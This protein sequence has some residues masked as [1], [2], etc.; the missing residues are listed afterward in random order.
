[1]IKRKPQNDLTGKRFGILTVI[2]YLGKVNGRAG[3]WKCLCDCGKETNVNSS[4]LKRKHTKSCGCWKQNYK[5]LV[6]K[7]INL[8]TVLEKVGPTKNGKY[9]IYK[10][11]CKCGNIVERSSRS[12]ASPRIKSCGCLRIEKGVAPLAPG[13]SGLNDIFQNYKRNAKNRNLPFDLTKDEFKK[14]SKE[15]C[16]YCGTTPSQ[17]SNVSIN[18]R[19]LYNGID[20][21]NSQIGYLTSNVVTCCKTCNIAKNTMNQNEFLNWIN[22]V[23]DYQNKSTNPS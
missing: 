18:G 12:L 17:I 2:K 16:H 14:L 4:T 15:N 19:Y 23:Y 13:E 8:F 9:C 10:C 21:L 11:E 22:K 5:S 20:R 1:M 3:M 6:G 7:Q